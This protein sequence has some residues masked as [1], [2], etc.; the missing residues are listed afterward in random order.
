[1]AGSESS[2]LAANNILTQLPDL[3]SSGAIRE[4]FAT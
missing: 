2:V 1:M 4:F 3:N